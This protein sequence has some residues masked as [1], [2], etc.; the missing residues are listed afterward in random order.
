MGVVKKHC[1]HLADLTERTR[2][3]QMCVMF[4]HDC[5][6]CMGATTFALTK[7]ASMQMQTDH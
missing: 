7:L 3:T 1:R 6:C 2:I 5:Q 4:V